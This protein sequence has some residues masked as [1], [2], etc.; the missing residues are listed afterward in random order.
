MTRLAGIDVA[1]P[2]ALVLPIY[3]LALL[4][5]SLL[6]ARLV[7]VVTAR[8]LARQAGRAGAAPASPPPRLAIPVATIVLA[9]GLLLVLP[10]L[11]FPGR[12]GRWLVDALTVVFILACALVLTRIAVAAIMEYGARHPS[13]G[14]A[15]GVG[16]GAVRVA[17]SILAAITALQALG[18]PVAPL[19]T[20]LGVG[21]LAVALALQDTLANFFAGIYLLADRP[22]GAGDYIKLHDGEEGYVE[23]IGW[24][25]SRLR[26]A[27]SSTVIV[28]N[29]KLSQAILTNFHRPNATVVMTVPITVA[30]GAEVGAVEAALRDELR[31]ATEEI[32]ELRESK[33]LVRL[34]DLNQS[35]QVWSCIVEVPSF[36]AQG[37]AGHE[38]R[39]RLLTRL[40]NEHVALG[41]PE[42]LIKKTKNE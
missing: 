29:Q 33:P 31:R 12:I 32:A 28:P 36:D 9:G 21:S 18:V 20:T 3:V 15:L 39:K 30:H 8:W 11:A 27:S 2:P 41:V 5:L 26:T 16:R 22:V 14:P 35:G 7:H 19:L 13:I 23:T 40:A 17:I 34:T 1:A 42:R 25:S 4:G 38:L 37:I 6:V 24:R 10:E